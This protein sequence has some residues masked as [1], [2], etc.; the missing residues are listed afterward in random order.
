MAHLLKFLTEI[1]P[2]TSPVR[3]AL[4]NYIK[5]FHNPEE[6]LSPNFFEVFFC[7]MMDYPHWYSNKS[8]LGHEISLLLKN[9][10]GFYQNKLQLSEIKQP[11]SLQIFE[12]ESQ[13]DC[14]DL[15]HE[16]LIS[17]F[18][19]KA[20]IQLQMDQKKWIAFVLSDNHRL[21]VFQLDKKFVIRNRQLEPL[22]KNLGLEYDANLELVNDKKFIFEIS[23][24]HLI[25]FQIKNEKVSGCI[26]RGY[27]FQKIQD[28]TD[29]K[30][31]EI[32]RLFWPLKRAEQF[33]LTRD[34][35]PF[36]QDL[37]KKLYDITQGLWE[38]NSES[39]QNYMS[40]L[41]SQS[42]SA[43][44][45]V[46]IGDKPL[47]DLILKVRQILTSEKSEICQTIQPKTPK[48]H[49]KNP[50]LGSINS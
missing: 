2:H 12:V 37:T 41:L 9:F 19:S 13:S 20:Q 16:Y 34:S 24:H 8:H 15:L 5:S 47:E 7:H 40:L 1:N 48:H 39:W 14:K 32:P 46:Y 10:N 44:E 36:Y 45:N 26:T 28:F 49:S 23:P 35:D 33:F 30:I 43:L 50:E 27:M 25:Q 11:E 38:K 22:R 21:H 42:D 4:Y 29:L 31:H 17:Q 3:L 18:G 6:S